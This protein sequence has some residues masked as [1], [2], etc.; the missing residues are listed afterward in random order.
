MSKYEGYIDGIFFITKNS[1]KDVIQDCE[2]AVHNYDEFAYCSER[3][4]VIHK[5]G[6]VV[7]RG[8]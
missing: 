1:L 3:D 8:E 2:Y 6:E 4:I 7:Y 5:D